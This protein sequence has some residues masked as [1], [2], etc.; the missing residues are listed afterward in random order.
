MTGKKTS[1][2]FI[3]PRFVGSTDMVSQRNR[4]FGGTYMN[5][6]AVF[7]RMTGSTGFLKRN[8]NGFHQLVK[9]LFF[10][11]GRGGYV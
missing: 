11:E 9:Y 7:S 8:Q 5:Y 10:K 2:L 6:G 1:I 3:R 4:L